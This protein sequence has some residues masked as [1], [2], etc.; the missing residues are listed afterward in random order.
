MTSRRRTERDDDLLAEQLAWLMDRCIKVGPWSIGLDG[1]LGLI[2]GIGDVTSGAFSGL[3]IL[4]AIQN[5]VPKVAILRML[6][7]VAIDSILGVVPVVGD[8]FDFAFKANVKNV[9]IYRQSLSGN[10]EPLKDW[11]FITVVLVIF[12]ALLAIPVLELLFI[13]SVLGY[14]IW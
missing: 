10:R 12:L 4:R 14:Y 1:I 7:N 5:G 6:V 11:L 3:I 13:A 9:E 8:L 2:P